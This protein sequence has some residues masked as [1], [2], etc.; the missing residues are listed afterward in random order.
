MKQNAI[1][2]LTI[3]M[4]SGLNSSAQSKLRSPDIYA[5]CQN[6]SAAA[7]G[8]IWP[9]FSPLK[10]TA[11][12]SEEGK[13][14]IEFSAKDVFSWRLFDEYFA[15][16]SLEDNLVITF[17]EA[18]HAFQ[19]DPERKGPKWGAENALLIFEYQDSSAR[20][21]AL[22]SIESQ[23][24]RSALESKNKKELEK[25]VRQFL[26]IRKLRQKELDPRFVEFEKNAELNEGLAEYAG[27]KAAILELQNARDGKT[28]IPFQNTSPAQFI[29][30]KYEKLDSITTIG[31]NIRLKFYYTGS[32]MGFVLD[33]LVKDWKLKA[34][35][36]GIAPQDLL[37]TAVRIPLSPKELERTLKTYNYEKTLAVETRRAESR[38]EANLALLNKTLERP[39]RKYVIDTS[40]LSEPGQIRNFDPMN[41][42]KINSELRV[43]TR[44]VT[45]AAESLFTAKFLQAV[46]EDLGNHRYTTVLEGDEKVI[47]DGKS[48][49]MSVSGEFH[50]TDSLKIESANFNFEASTGGVI[51]VTDKGVMINLSDK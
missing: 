13:N 41:V 25:L 28:E 7:A 3:L 34:Q 49:D 35:M 38:R 19:R 31:Q 8:Q 26:A 48:I 27:T 6:A 36:N 50:F 5:Y 51:R 29:R 45:F 44:S 24:L 20:N 46:V 30:S 4:F 37:L 2:F 15:T 12:K 33:R 42:T 18:F 21:N 47:A 16:H 14:Y 39:G 22:F 40:A 10:Y 23:I 43:H 9:G 11:L 17:H 32:A 1:I